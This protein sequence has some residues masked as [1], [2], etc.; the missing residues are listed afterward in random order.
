MNRSRAYATA[1]LPP[2]GS[3]LVAGGFDGSS[4]LAKA[5]LY[6]PGTNQWTLTGSMATA[7]SLHTATLLDNG[8]TAAE[9]YVPAT[10][11]WQP[12]ASL[13]WSRHTAPWGSVLLADGRVLVVG[14]N[15]NLKR[16]EVWD[17]AAGFWTNTGPLANARTNSFGLVRLDD[18]RVLLDGGAQPD[19]WCDNETG[20]CDAGRSGDNPRRW[21]VPFATSSSVSRTPAASIRRR[22]PRQSRCERHSSKRPAACSASRTS[23]SRPTGRSSTESSVSTRSISAAPSSTYDQ[24][25]PCASWRQARTRVRTRSR[26]HRRR[27]VGVARHGCLNPLCS[28]PRRR[29]YGRGDRHAR[30]RQAVEDGAG[31]HDGTLYCLETGRR[32][33]HRAARR[34]LEPLGR[35]PTLRGVQPP[36]GPQPLGY[37]AGPATLAA[38]RRRRAATAV[39]RGSARRPASP[40]S[41]S[42]AAGPGRLARQR[43]CP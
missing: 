19:V 8:A 3:V 21:L 24:A 23:S 35:S 4:H 41:R 36:S 14:G 37:A 43:P 40:R 42:A 27:H 22:P 38:R 26:R 9:I 28:R 2:D 13:N 1:T 33:H 34:F 5:E 20:E 16:A 7:R 18:G 31:G 39:K 12:A 15:G 10:R 11:S 6:N 30:V 29:R 25:A 17:P 32:I